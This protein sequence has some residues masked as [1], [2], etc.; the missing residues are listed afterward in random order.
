MNTTILASAVLTLAMYSAAPARAA[1]TIWAATQGGIYKSI[2]S[3]ATWQQT[4]VTVSNPLLKG[5]DPQTPVGAA[6]ALDPQQPATVYF[7]G[8][9]LGSS[10]W[11]FYRSTDNGKSWTSTFLIGIPIAYPSSYW[12]TWI[13][14]DPVLTNVIYLGW[15]GGVAKS[16]DYGA[17]FS[18]LTMPNLPVPGGGP[19]SPGGLS[20]D[21]TS[22]GVLYMSEIR[23]V[24]RSA[25]FG[26]SWTALAPVVAHQSGLLIGNVVV[27]PRNHNL[28]Y[29][30][31]SGGSPTCGPT[32]AFVECGLWR[33]ADGGQSWN[34]VAP[35]GTYEEVV[36]DAR[37]AGLYVS[38]N[39]LGVGT[40][41]LQSTDNGNTWNPV[42]NKSAPHLIADPAAGATLYGYIWADNEWFKSTDGGVT[43]VGGEIIKS[44]NAGIY[45]MTVPRALGNVSGASFQ[46]GPVAP[47]SI[48]SALGFDLATAPLGNS[49]ATVPTTL[50]GTIVTVTDSTGASRQ[51]PLF[52][53]S[54]GQVNYE[55]PAG[56]AS[57][58]ATVTVQS[59]DGVT[60]TAPLGIVAVSPGLF[61]LNAAG[62]AAAFD[63]RVSGGN[64]TYEN[65]YQLD[66]S[67]NVIPKPI[68]LSPATDSVY[69]LLYGTGLRGAGTTTATIGGVAVPVTFA[70]AQGQFAGEDQVNV[71]P[72]PQSLA[73][74]GN[75]QIILTSDGIPANA[76]NVTI[77]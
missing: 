16:T 40:G 61:E 5:T 6:I 74:R 24:W 22:S 71:G 47:E 21:P 7:V 11:G 10:G 4:P 51:A 42:S 64:Q 43:L 69:L 28:L 52:Y 55:I 48:V 66:A 62:L 34:N 23:F 49:S 57:G 13:L 18:K 20:V 17:T 46:S 56:T 67:N 45:D 65:V 72:L 54:P 70:G 33:S 50:G 25:D 76:V 2:D 68:D 29:V 14:V 9:M 1:T 37:S 3:G 32:T 75:V 31:N 63:I 15:P 73:G 60:S 30:G 38:G 19:G 35:V 39:P 53:V 58:V 36:F 41:V 44:G 77:K 59:G 12:T 26:A 27:D 8:R